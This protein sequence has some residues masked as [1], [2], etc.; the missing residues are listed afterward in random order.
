MCLYLRPGMPVPAGMGW[1]WNAHD[2]PGMKVSDFRSNCGIFGFG[3]YCVK[4]MQVI[5]ELAPISVSGSV[6][7]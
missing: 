1:L 5:S 7:P 4:V 3:K 6:W 2:V